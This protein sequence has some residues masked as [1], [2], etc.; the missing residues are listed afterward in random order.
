MLVPA[1]IH[2]RSSLEAMFAVDGGVDLFIRKNEAISLGNILHAS[3]FAE[4][5]EAGRL[6]HSGFALDVA[7]GLE[8][9]QQCEVLVQAAI[10]PLLVKR[11]ELE[12]FRFR[13]E[14]AGLGEGGFDFVTIFAVARIFVD[15]EGK[16]VFPDGAA[17]I[18]APAVG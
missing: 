7:H 2:G 4:F 5:E 10:D 18:Q 8:R 16:E 6:F 1:E 14:D 12:L 15:T 3:H 11:Q 9:L 17:A 13:G